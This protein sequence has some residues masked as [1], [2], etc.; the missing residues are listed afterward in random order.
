MIII[1]INIFMSSF[2]NLIQMTSVERIVEY[3][4]LESEADEY[5]DDYRPPEKWP[6]Q[7]NIDFKDMSLA[8]GDDSPPVLKNINI[9]IASAEKVNYCCYFYIIICTRKG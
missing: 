3:T 6:H 7:G 2:N 9:R 5:N 8:Y 1:V 4:Q